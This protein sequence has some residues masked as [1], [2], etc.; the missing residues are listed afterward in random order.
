VHFPALLE[1]LKLT[2]RAA[3]VGFDWQ[4]TDQIFDKL[5]EELDELKEAMKNRDE[6][7]IG[8]EVGDLLFVVVNL[9]RRLG[10]EPETALKKT[11]RKFRSRFRFIED[12]LKAAD[13][14][15]E[16]SS[17]EEMDSLWNAAKAKAV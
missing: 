2:K 12:E 9:A 10:I 11:N 5:A 6:G 7:E 14:N 17:L 3:K 16:E 4:D 8:E 13:K 15:L 1:G